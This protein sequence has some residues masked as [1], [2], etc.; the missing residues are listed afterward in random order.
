M[1]VKVTFDIS[2]PDKLNLDAFLPWL[3]SDMSN[4]ALELNYRTLPLEELWYNY[5][6]NTDFGWVR[7]SKGDLV[8][9]TIEYIIYQ[10]FST[11]Q[12]QKSGDDYKLVPDSEQVISGTD[13]PI[14]MLANIMNEGTLDI[15]SYPYFQFIFDLYE[16]NLQDM[17][18]WWCTTYHSSVETDNS[19]IT[20]DT[21]S[22]SSDGDGESE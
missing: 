17:L 20:S 8:V 7:D 21:D 5:F 14:E 1:G 10:Y 16:D 3:I 13:I 6:K 4:R 2:N 18:D 12:I 9:P 11:L 15:P 22:N 19:P